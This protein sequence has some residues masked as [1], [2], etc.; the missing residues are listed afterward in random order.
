M[1][2]SRN[3]VE[4][5]FLE[6]WQAEMR[7]S[8]LFL[9]PGVSCTSA[10]ICRV[11]F[12]WLWCNSR[13]WRLVLP[14]GHQLKVVCVC[15]PSCPPGWRAGSG[16]HPGLGSRGTKCSLSAW[17]GALPQMASDEKVSIAPLLCLRQPCCSRGMIT[18]LDSSQEGI[19]G[20]S[21]CFFYN[22]QA[23]HILAFLFLSTFLL[24]LS[25]ICYD[26][27]SFGRFGLMWY[28]NFLF[29]AMS[30]VAI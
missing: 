28:F 26:S 15:V 17:E 22:S 14:Q 23:C 4:I 9:L 20:Q 18:E 3:K 29:V 7:L 25:F 2:G 1:A 24:I 13:G 21:R 5:V 19:W 6:P 12:W 11:V 16:L 30:L 8:V 10:L 27:F